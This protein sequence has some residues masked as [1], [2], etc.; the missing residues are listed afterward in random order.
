[1][2]QLAIAFVSIVRD[3]I[4]KAGAA[5]LCLARHECAVSIARRVLLSKGHTSRALKADV[6][7][8]TSRTRCSSI[9]VELK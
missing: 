3:L 5:G 1:M 8:K 9:A 2:R 4:V 7:R 6:P